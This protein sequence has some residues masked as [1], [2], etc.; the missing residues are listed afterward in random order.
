MSFEMVA[1]TGV[2]GKARAPRNDDAVVSNFIPRGLMASEFVT[3]L[4]E[5]KYAK[6]ASLEPEEKL[7]ARVSVL[8]H[9]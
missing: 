8:K 4:L 7:A 1:A 6:M 9:V 5:A 2:A 3:E